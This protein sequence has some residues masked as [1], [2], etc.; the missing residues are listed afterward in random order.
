MGKERAVVLL[1]GGLDSATVLAVALA[2][3]FDV[4]AITFS[5][6]QRHDVEIECARRLAHKGRVLEHVIVDIPSEIFSG[7]ALTGIDLKDVPKHGAVPGGPGIP[8]TYVPARNILFLSY[9]LAFAESRMADT[10]FIGAHSVDYSGYP[11]CRGEFFE[12]FEKMA[13]LGTKCGVEGRPIRVQTPL[14]NL[15][16]HEIIQLGAE[17]GVDY[18]ITHSCYDPDTEGRACGECDSCR[19]RKKGFEAAG[20]PDPTKYGK[21]P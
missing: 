5:Y 18:S 1:S 19:I 17:L 6:G 16:K 12:A 14:L 9:A 11:D 3:G 21:V 15:G 10:V 2:G 7:S 20:I 8:V 13:A 4:L